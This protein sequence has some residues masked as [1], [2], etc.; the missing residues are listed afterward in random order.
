M[1][2]K[3][4]LAYI[5]SQSVWQFYESDWMN[6]RWN[7]DTIQ[8][9]PGASS[10]NSKA[11]TQNG[12]FA[13]KPYFSVR[14]G[15]TDPDF[16]DCL[17]IGS[18]EIHQYPRIRALGVM[19]VEIGIGKSLEIDIQEGS[20]IAKRNKVWVMAKEYSDSEKGWPGFPFAPYRSAVKH[21]LEPENFTIRP[22]AKVQARAARMQTRSGKHPNQISGQ[23]KSVLQNAEG[24]KAQVKG[25]KLQTEGADAQEDE[26]EAE[27][28]RRRRKMLYEKVVSPLE[29][30][31]QVCG[32][33]KDLSALGPV[34]I[35]Q[36]P[37]LA[38]E[39]PEP[40]TPKKS[41]MTGDL[42]QS[43][44]WLSNI[45]FLNSKIIGGLCNRSEGL[46]ARIKIAIIDTGFEE[47]VP[48]FHLP[49]RRRRI[50][51]WKDWVKDSPEPTD[52]AGHGTHIVSLIMTIAPDA[53]VYVARVAEDRKGLE[54]ASDEIV[55][56]VIPTW[57]LYLAESEVLAN[58][59]Q[60]IEWA[61]TEW[62]VDVISMSFGYRKDKP[63]IKN[64]ILRGVI[65]RSEEILYFAAAANF[66]VREPEMFPA[67]FGSVISLRGSNANGFFPDFNPP[68]RE[69]EAIVYGT[70][71]V[72]V[73]GASIRP[74]GKQEPK[75]GSSIATAV[76]A[77]IAAVLLEY[78]T[79][80]TQ[81]SDDSEILRK[82]KTQQGML[83]MF[84]SLAVRS[85]HNEGHLC[86]S[87]QELLGITE[88]Q[89]WAKFE[90]ALAKID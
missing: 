35:P 32:W 41:S 29:T 82:L 75:S 23:V 15:E 44:I 56:K 68:P 83:A 47:T 38:V 31:V 67:R 39:E 2:M 12:I 77:G 51:D 11:G 74:D 6:T 8:F 89:R 43:K 52:I 81:K 80:K 48:F 53:D 65:S 22:S 78:V 14:F 76:A 40:L 20:E 62:K 63:V 49:H 50:K 73:P 71:G 46:P 72:E 33:I 37:Q 69:N 30:L 3:G 24:S 66:G 59:L 21:C 1:E 88:A 79:R 64:A 60:A 54:G 36:V 25:A 27:T 4:A 26:E 5:V 19:L 10:E 34:E 84:R 58:F 61:W 9:I 13:W 18:G 7:S 55:A 87:V 85:L 70:L 57:A 86:V 90:N 45:E 16:G 28:I 42:K 17:A